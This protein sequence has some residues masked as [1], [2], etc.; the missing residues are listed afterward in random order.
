M[1]PYYEA[2]GITI[3]CGDCREVLKQLPDESVQ[4]CV[5]SPPY[6]GL[7]DYGHAGQLGQEATPEQYTEHLVLVFEEVRRM[8]RDDGI[9]WLNLGDSYSSGGRTTQ[10]APTLRTSTNDS[11]SGKH[12]NLNGLCC[13]PGSP[14]NCKPK[15]LIGIP[16][17][18]AFALRNAGWYLRQEI[19][20]SKPNPMPES[21]TDRCTKSHEQ[22]FLLSKSAHYHYDADAIKEPC[23]DDM[24]WR[25]SQGYT[26]GANG[27]VDASRHDID[28]LRGEHAKE[29]KSEGRNK[30]SVW[31]V[32]TQPFS[33][34]HFATFPPDLIK[35]CILAGC[36]VGGTVLD[37]FLGSGTTAMV[38]IEIGRRCVGI[39]LNP[40]YANLAIERTNVTKGLPL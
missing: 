4:C 1:T 13:R 6:W 28:T 7:R 3:F 11:A 17:M 5:T 22:I 31:T 34:A 32:P 18:V 24:Q 36:P 8:L 10:V 25:A 15:D 40:D 14:E 20:W 2:D 29:I 27:K 39:E 35:P 21:V 12:A 38:A 23:S 30:R 9:L 19:I 16:W 26:R 33:E 37:P